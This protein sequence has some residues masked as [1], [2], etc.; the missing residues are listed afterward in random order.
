MSKYFPPPKIYL[1]LINIKTTHSKPFMEI[2]SL[3]NT[4]L[5]EL[6]N[7]QP[8]QVYLSLHIID[9]DVGP[10]V[11]ISGLLFQPFCNISISG[12]WDSFMGFRLSPITLQKDYY[13]A[14]FQLFLT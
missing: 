8:A 7:P 5:F 4:P 12:I 10:S 3:T 11:Y 1:I 9:K 2:N 14:N 13:I 6:Q